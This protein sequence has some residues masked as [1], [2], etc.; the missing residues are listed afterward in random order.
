MHNCCIAV[1]NKYRE[2]PARCND[3]SLLLAPGLY[4]RFLTRRNR[5]YDL[6]T[7]NLRSGLISVGL[8][9]ELIDIINP[10]GWLG[11]MEH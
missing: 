10:Q 1:F 9:I 11:S 8:F 7:E 5:A 3:I 2:V 6:L 4:A